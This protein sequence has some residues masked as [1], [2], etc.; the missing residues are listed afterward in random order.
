MIKAT[1]MNFLHLHGPRCGKKFI[2]VHKYKS[3]RYKIHEIG[4]GTK[5][6]YLW[7]KR[8]FDMRRER[9]NLS[10]LTAFTSSVLNPTNARCPWRTNSSGHAQLWMSTLSFGDRNTTNWLFPNLKIL[11]PHFRCVTSPTSPGPNSHL[12]FLFWHLWMT[13]PLRT[14][15]N[16]CVNVAPN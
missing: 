3:R 7:V 12:G 15:V 8:F 5:L 16:T 1:F 13:Y 6:Y 4:S 2:V 14:R 10:M 11:S 9:H